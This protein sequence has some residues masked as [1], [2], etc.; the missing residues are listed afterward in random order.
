MS[1]VSPPKGGSDVQDALISTQRGPDY[2]Y[3][4]G[5]KNKSN[6]GKFSGS[7][8]QIDNISQYVERNLKRT[9]K[10]RHGEHR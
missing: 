5:K 6:K 10:P 9:V 4:K 1:I 8:G 3:I 7:H 2:A